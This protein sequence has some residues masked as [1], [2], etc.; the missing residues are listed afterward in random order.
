MRLVR[1]M[2]QHFWLITLALLVSSA[3]G[4]HQY[5][6]A[7]SLGGLA[8]NQ[9]TFWDVAV[10]TIM[11]APLIS[12]GF[13]TRCPRCSN[14]GRVLL[15][16][17]F[18]GGIFKV[19]LLRASVE[20]RVTQWFARTFVD[21][22]I[23]CGLSQTGFA[24]VCELLQRGHWIVLVDIKSPPTRLPRLQQ[25]L[26][27][28]PRNCRARLAVIEGDATY[29]EVLQMA[30]VRHCNAVYAV[31]NDDD[32]NLE[33]AACAKLLRPIP[34]DAE[35][36]LPI[37][38]YFK[39]YLM[40]DPLKDDFK[41]FDSRAMAGR[42]L[43]NQYPADAP[44][45]AGRDF[46]K[47]PHAMVIGLGGSASRRSCS[48]PGQPPTMRAESASR[49]LLLIPRSTKPAG[50]SRNAIRCLTRRSR[51][52]WDADGCRQ[53]HEFAGIGP[54]LRASVGRRVL[55]RRFCG[56]MWSAGNSG[57]HLFVSGQ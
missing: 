42:E 37:H 31:T 36:T 12:A 9:H 16:F 32:V 29:T 14:I 50:L 18:I 21:H 2:L 22:T 28:M 54:A 48:C 10:L 24:L 20:K 52:P 26:Q 38:V 43:V 47:A 41:L 27:N 5:L 25:A 23:V 4:W 35:A 1:G 49:S 40:R 30:G 46:S 53:L 3:I 33:I 7:H 51:L 57:R 55:R 56:R 39:D 44:W 34:A 17:V 13:W 8:A 19:A 45:L 11:L 6:A 15:P